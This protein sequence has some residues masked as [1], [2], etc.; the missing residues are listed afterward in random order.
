[1]HILTIDDIVP[2]GVCGAALIAY[3]HQNPAFSRV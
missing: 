2:N 3:S 1:M